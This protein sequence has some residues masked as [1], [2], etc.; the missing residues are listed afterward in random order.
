[1][2]QA[3]YGIMCEVESHPFPLDQMLFM[4]WRAYVSRRSPAGRSMLSNML[5]GYPSSAPGTHWRRKDGN[6]F[7]ARCGAACSDH[8]NAESQAKNEALPTFLY[9]MPFDEHRIFLEETS[10]VARPEVRACSRE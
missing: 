7:R 6:D 2:V 8:L 4:D 1:V 3:A 9:A 10:L 5:A